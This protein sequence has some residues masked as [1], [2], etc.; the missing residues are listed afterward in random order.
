MSF[1]PHRSQFR[2][3]EADEIPP[4]IIGCEEQAL[5]IGCPYESSRTGRRRQLQ[6]SV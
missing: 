5:S 4:E 3:I 6:G 2:L 1:H